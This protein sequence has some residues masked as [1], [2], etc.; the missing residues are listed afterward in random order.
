MRTYLLTSGP[1]AV[2]LFSGLIFGLVFAAVTRFTA[3]PP[4]SWQ[5]AAIAGVVAGVLVGGTLAYASVRRQ[6][7]LR[8]AAGDLSPEQQLDAY[9][10]AFSGEIPVDPQIRGASA[11]IARG[12]IAEMSQFRFLNV[13]V[14]ALLTLGAVVNLTAGEYILAALLLA[15]ALADGG[16]LYQLKRVRRQLQRLSAGSPADQSG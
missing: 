12:R 7:D 1:W 5:V 13:I 11:R 14:A 16:Q 15:A 10:A 9:R 2:G 3:P 6:R 8:A 4:V